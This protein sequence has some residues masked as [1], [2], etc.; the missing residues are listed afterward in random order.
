MGGFSDDEVEAFHKELELIKA[1]RTWMNGHGLTG[2]S[3]Y[4]VPLL[5]SPDRSAHTRGRK[6][7]EYDFLRAGDLV[8]DRV[9]IEEQRLTDPNSRGSDSNGSAIQGQQRSVRNT[10][11]PGRV[12]GGAKL[13]GAFT[14]SK[15]STPR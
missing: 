13:K 12:N 11:L 2:H 15:P 8:D 7:N 6:N 4:G 9:R 5:F 10:E 14:F 1:K 3:M